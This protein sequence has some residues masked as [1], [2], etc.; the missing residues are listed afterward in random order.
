MQPAPY[1]GLEAVRD[2]GAS[3]LH[4]VNAAQH[5]KY[6]YP[7]TYNPEPLPP[8]PKAKRTICGLSKPIFWLA[9]AITALVIGMIGLGI[10]LGVSLGKAQSANGGER[11]GNLA[12]QTTSATAG[13][14]ISSSPSE[15]SATQTRSTLSTET[16]SA[17][18][19]TSSPSTTARSTTSSSASTGVLQTICPSANGTIR[20]A[21]LTELVT[22][23]WDEC[24]TLC[25]NMNYRQVRTD[26]GPSWN[27]GG[28]AA[29]GGQAPGTCWCLGGPDKE[30]VENKG[31]VVGV[32]IEV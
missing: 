20:Q 21:D 15:S 6:Y 16:S 10:G 25:N 2:H 9:V 19:T 3:D 13:P 5:R 24:L 28:T 18:T 11:A 7:P 30:V 12:G 17:S 26:V 8:T 23:T 22:K 14:T 32:P 27:F 29:G 31:S 1:D 4:V